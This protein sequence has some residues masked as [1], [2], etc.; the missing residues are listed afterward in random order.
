MHKTVREHIQALEQKRNVLSEQV[1]E[2]SNCRQ[3]Q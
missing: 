2:E 3:A 1:M